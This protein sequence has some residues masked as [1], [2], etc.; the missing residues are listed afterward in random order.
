MIMDYLSRLTVSVTKQIGS[1]IKAIS[2]FLG[3]ALEGGGC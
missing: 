3:G 1:C 2:S